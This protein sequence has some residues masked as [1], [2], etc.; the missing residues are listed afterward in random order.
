MGVTIRDVA[1]EAQVSVATVSRITSNTGYPVGAATRKRVIAAIEKL[2]Y[3]PSEVAKGLSMRGSTLIGVLAPDMA[4]QYYAEITRGIEDVAHAEGYQVVFC[5]SD[6]DFDRATAYVDSLVRRRVAGLVVVGGGS[7]VA[8][9]PDDVSPYEAAVVMVGRPSTEFSTVQADNEHAGRRLADHFA[10]LGHRRLGYLAGHSES[11][12]SALRYEAI[13]AALADRDA[14]APRV[15]RGAY[16]EAGGYRAATTLLGSADRPT[17]II[18]ANDRMAMGALAAA[19]DLG[20]RVPD[21]VALAGFDNTPISEYL[22]PALT[23]FSLSSRDMGAQ[24]MRLIL[25]GKEG[26]NTIQHVTVRGD[27]VIRESCGSAA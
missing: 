13:T 25:A 12:A 21:D 20:L 3:R 19:N 9:V 5:S 18:A 11:S 15:E 24:A 1:A 26:D 14:A 6:R 23:T 27:L 2:G 17:A 4:N 22:R 10:D 8:L 7:E 16:T